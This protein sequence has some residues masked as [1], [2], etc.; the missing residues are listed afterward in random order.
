MVTHTTVTSSIVELRLGT[1]KTRSSPTDII[2]SPVVR[3]VASRTDGGT[4]KEQPTISAQGTDRIHNFSLWDQHI[5]GIPT[6]PCSGAVV[7][8]RKSY[9]PGR[10]RKDWDSS[11]LQ[12]CCKGTNHPRQFYCPVSIQES[13]A[14]RKYEP[15]SIGPA[16]LIHFQSPSSFS[17]SQTMEISSAVRV[18]E[19]IADFALETLNSWRALDSVE[20]YFLMEN[21]CPRT[22]R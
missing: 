16:I 1:R 12:R 8:T 18:I 17:A 11:I 7:T 2:D 19:I 21:V 5:V 15:N 9:S 14:R 10:N 22:S 3:R 13:A 6:L 20:T 4:F